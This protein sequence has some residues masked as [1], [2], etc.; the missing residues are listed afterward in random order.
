MDLKLRFRVAPDTRL[1]LADIDPDQNG[2]LDDRPAIADRLAGLR[3]NLAELQTRLYAERKRGV[4]ICL[5]GMDTA[6]K[7]GVINRALSAM[8]PL[9]CRV[10]SFKQPTPQ[11]TAHDFLWRYH[12]A[13]PERGW[14]QI[15]NRSHYESVVADRVQGLL[16][17]ATA[18]R[19][20]VEI[21]AFEEYLIHNGTVVIKLFLHISKAEQ[22]AR[23]KSRL[24]DPLKRWKISESD[25]LQRAKWDENMT[26]YGDAISRTSTAIAPWYVIPSN[27][28]WFRDL[29]V[30]EI[31]TGSLDALAITLPKP[32]VDIEQILKRYHQAASSK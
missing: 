1:N 9:G 30:A 19:R 20:C 18:K 22:L 29:A 2:G 28:K 31:V 16:D 15:F 10:T 32:S 3:R 5:Q 27:R 21:N 11:E 12:A 8:N 6:G 14:V 25:Y 7:D 4:L 17:P 26:A 23:F 13:L 24:D